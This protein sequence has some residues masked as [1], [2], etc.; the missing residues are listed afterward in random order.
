MSENKLLVV[1]PGANYSVD[2]PLLYYA[3]FK[4]HTKGYKEITINYGEL[5]KSNSLQAVI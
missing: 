5:I 4:F 1:F 3:R 2:S